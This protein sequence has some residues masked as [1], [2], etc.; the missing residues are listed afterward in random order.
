MKD[1]ELLISVIVPIFN[2]EKYLVNSISSIC[3]QTYQH[4]EIILVNDGSTDG[5]QEIC[6]S[7][8]KN[9]D[10]IVIIQKENGGEASARNVGLDKA[11]GELI[12]FVDADDYIERDFLSVL[13]AAIREGERDIAI[14]SYVEETPSGK[15]L[16]VFRFVNENWTDGSGFLRFLNLSVLGGVWNKLFRAEMIKKYEIRFAPDIKHGP[17]QLFIGEY[18]AHTKSGIILSKIGYHYLYIANSISKKTFSEKK[19]ERTGLSW[20]DSA[21]RLY[22]YVKEDLTLKKAYESFLAY[23]VQD[24]L[25]LITLFRYKDKE[26]EKDL[27]NKLRKTMKSWSRSRSLGMKTKILMWLASLSM[28][29]Y[30]IVIFMYRRRLR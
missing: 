30:R 9:D 23:R 16:N 25:L 29:L 5:S 11:R 27:R 17:D 26:L 12:A 18:L 14:C 13:Y 4:I 24:T 3:N 7:F 15:V 6:E 10:R 21:E 20:V 2:A 28:P 22:P 8:Q 19:F 1:K